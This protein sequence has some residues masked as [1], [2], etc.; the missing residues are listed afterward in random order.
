[1]RGG[2]W[3]ESSCGEA[4]LKGF[5]EVGFCSGLDAFREKKEQIYYYIYVYI[6]GIYL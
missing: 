3:V 5:E 1:M 6:Y 2:E 4:T